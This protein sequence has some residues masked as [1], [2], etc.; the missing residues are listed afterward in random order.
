MADGNVTENGNAA[1]ADGG[2]AGTNSSE[3]VSIDPNSVQ[4]AADRDGNRGRTGRPRGRPRKDGK[5]A[6]T[7]EPAA[8]GS[9]PK[10]GRPKKAAA[11]A[12][13]VPSLTLVL[14]FF[15]GFVAAR[16]GEPTLALDESEATQVAEAV[17]NVGKHYN[18]PVSP[19]TQAWIG[20]GMTV[21]SIYGGKLAAIKFRKEMKPAAVSGAE[22][23]VSGIITKIRSNSVQ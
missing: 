20:F 17:S 9:E 14:S 12:L 2:S 23:D 16:A 13:D 7:A 22:A 11:A 3:P 6:G 5:P 18:I 8:A 15:T 1:I 10:P 21:A 19:V 4:P